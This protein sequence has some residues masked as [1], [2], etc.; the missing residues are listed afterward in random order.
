V[1][2]EETPREDSRYLLYLQIIFL[3]NFRLLPFL[4]LTPCEHF[5]IGSKEQI[6]FLVVTWGWG[7]SKNK[8]KTKQPPYETRR[9]V[10]YIVGGNVGKQQSSHYK[11]FV[12]G[13]F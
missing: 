3:I 2:W 12:D 7:N 6:I 11:L 5:K 9:M 4:G 13:P 10:T 8:A 1:G